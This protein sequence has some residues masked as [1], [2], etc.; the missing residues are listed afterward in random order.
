[1]GPRDTSNCCSLSEDSNN[2][3]FIDHAWLLLIVKPIISGFSI[4]NEILVL[5]CGD[6]LLRSQMRCHMATLLLIIQSET[7]SQ[8]MLRVIQRR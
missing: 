6:A 8:D 1:M 3:E 5:I 4:G 2:S 7:L